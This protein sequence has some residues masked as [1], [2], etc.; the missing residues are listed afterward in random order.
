MSKNAA[1]NGSLGKFRAW[2]VPAWASRAAALTVNIAV[3][4]QVQ[5][6]CTDALGLAPGLVGMVLLAS[7]LFDG[8]SDLIAGFIIDKTH[9]RL[10][11][12]R[13]Y[14]F[15]IMLAWLFTVFMF[16]T[17]ANF[18]TTGK[19]IWV[20]V[21][22]TMICSVFQTF[23]NASDS[24]YMSR[25]FLSADDQTKIL[26]FGSP[27]QMIC[28]IAAGA[29]LPILINMFGKQPGG[30]TK[31]SLIFAVPYGILGMARFLFIKEVPLDE[32]EET[33]DHLTFKMLLDNIR[34][35]KYIFIVSVFALLSGLIQNGGSAVSTYYFQYI[36]GD[37]NVAGLFGA[38]GIITPF[39]L[40]IMPLL[41]KKWSL[42]KLSLIGAVLGV[43]GNL[44]KFAGGTNLVTLIIGNL[45]AMI[46][47]MVTCM[48]NIFLIEC[49]DFGEWRN[50]V[51]VEGAL[52]SIKGFADK[53]GAGLASVLVGFV[54]QFAGY[55]GNA[56]VQSA[57]AN[58]AIIALY[59][60]VPL[61]LY[62][63][64]FIVMKQYDLDQK[65]PG[66]REEL[67]TRRNG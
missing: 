16:S 1:E 27:I 21:T 9:S 10:G 12:A 40:V 66:I 35:N 38:L 48:V 17:P 52:A 15:C 47:L 22:Y 65:L 13:P 39:I 58:H 20:F 11:K 51:R 41:M 50:G 30:W 54:L 56:A 7:K 45:I 60:L 59:S 49:M 23:L 18:G 43:I 32:K 6:Y 64:Q 36:Y 53:L 2:K 28:S 63:L 57:S 4:L 25:A 14:E 8:F 37:L 42:A 61:A 46:P 3:L 55:D 29:T 19:L 24:V 34:T 5:Y 44:I 33:S 26:S 67:N 62:V 31:I